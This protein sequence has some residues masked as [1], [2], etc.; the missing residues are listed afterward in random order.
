M[1]CSLNKPLAGVRAPRQFR[2]AEFLQFAEQLRVV[3]ENFAVPREQ[4]IK[5]A[6]AA[7]VA[8]QQF[9]RRRFFGEAGVARRGL[10]LRLNHRRLVA[11]VLIVVRFRHC[12]NPA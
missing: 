4:F 2:R 9:C 11:S 8:G 10:R 6:R 5:R 3:R 12:A 1:P 7:F